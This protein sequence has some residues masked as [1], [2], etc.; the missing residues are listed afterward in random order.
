MVIKAMAGEDDFMCRLMG[1]DRREKVVVGCPKKR[2]GYE[3]TDQVHFGRGMTVT[4]DTQ[5]R[6]KGPPLSILSEGDKPQQL[7]VQLNGDEEGM[8]DFP[9]DGLCGPIR[10]RTGTGGHALIGLPARS[11]ASP[12]HVLITHPPVF[13][14][15]SGVSSDKI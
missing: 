5:K 15:Q 13:L 10:F 9:I 7:R 14:P 11:V 8:D 2:T 3:G 1:Q 6:I 12:R 4:N